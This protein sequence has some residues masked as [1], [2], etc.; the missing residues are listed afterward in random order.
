MNREG[1][2]GMR[3]PASKK[4][5]KQEKAEVIHYLILM[6]AGLLET[7]TYQSVNLKLQ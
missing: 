7:N 4:K 6:S 3:T 1:K 5:L 2:N